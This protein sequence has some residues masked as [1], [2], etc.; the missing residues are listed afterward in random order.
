MKPLRC[1]MTEPSSFWNGKDRSPLMA[2]AKTLLVVDDDPGA[3]R[4][5]KYI[6][7]K[8]GC[9]VRTAASGAEAIA[10]AMERT[11]HVLITDLMMEGMGGFE[12][13]RTMRQV[14]AYATL[15]VIVLS[16]RGQVKDQDE[17]WNN[18]ITVMMTKPFSP[19]ELTSLIHR[20]LKL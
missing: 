2:N 16:A 14:P 4:L 17:E 8:T 7:G 13:T 9:E 6:L 3:R 18:K 12:L 15:P 5:L 19:I 11:I 10:L 1:W 20:L